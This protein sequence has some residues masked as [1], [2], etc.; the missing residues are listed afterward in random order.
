MIEGL[1][2]APEAY[3]RR[4]GLPLFQA[5][6]R[7]ENRGDH[8]RSRWIPRLNRPSRHLPRPMEREP[9]WSST[10]APK[11]VRESPATFSAMQ[12]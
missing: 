2:N 7:N 5:H 10:V 1:H 4:R 6:E 9:C 8:S 3:E 12:V 11:T